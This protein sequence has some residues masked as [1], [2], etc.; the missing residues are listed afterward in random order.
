M[1]RFLFIQE[2]V[3]SDHTIQHRDGTITIDFLESTTG[4]R[5]L[6]ELRKHG[7]TRKDINIGYMYP[8]VPE[9]TQVTNAGKPISYKDVTLT[10]AR[11]YEEQI[12]NQIIEEKPEVVIPNGR[13]GC[14]FLV[15]KVSITATRGIPVEKTVE[16]EDGDSHTF[17]ILPTFSM[18]YVILKP[19][20][21]RHLHVDLEMLSNFKEQGEKA[22]LPS[23]VEY[24]FVDDIEEVKKIFKYIKESK[25]VVAWDLET[26]TLKPEMKGSKA[27]VISVSWEEKTGY[28]I[29]IQHKEFE[30]AEEDLNTLMKLIEDFVKDKEV[31]KV[32]ANIKYDLRFLHSAYGFTEFNNHMDIQIAYWMVISQDRNNLRRLG[33]LAYEFTDMGGYDNDLE[34]WKDN[35]IREYRKEHKKP[36]VNEVDGSNFN[37]EWFPLKMLV[38]YAS[39]DVD[40]TLRIHNVL[41]KKVETNE[42][43][44]KLYTD[45]YPRMS[46][47]IAVTEAN[48]LKLD[49]DYARKIAKEYRKE[50][51]RIV[52]R[53]RELPS[54]QVVESEYKE[55][56]EMGLAEMAKKP[57]DRDKEIAKWRN[58]YKT[59]LKFNPRSG[60]DKGKVLFDVLNI[61]LP[62]ERDY[63]KDKP[64][65][66]KNPKTID[67]L[68][69]EDF[70]TNK[71]VLQEIVSG[72]YGEEASKLASLMLE[73]SSVATL[74]STFADKA[75]SDMA[76]DGAIHGNLNI[77]GTGT[78]RLSSSQPNLQNIPATHNN[79]HK[80]DYHHPIKRMYVSRFDDGVILEADYSAL[81]MRILGLVAGDPEM[82]KTF[83]EDG[84][85]HNN[86]ASII[87]HKAEDEVTY[88]EREASKAISFGIIYGKGIPGLATDLGI[89]PEEAQVV[90][91][92]FMSSKP[93][94]AQY[95]NSVHQ[96]V[97]EHGYVETLQGH[98]R[99]L[100]DIFGNRVAEAGAL[101]QSV[102]T[103]IQGTG[104]YLTNLS[105]VMLHEYIL[106]HNK[107]TKVIATVHDSI[108][109]DIPEDEIEEMTQVIRIIMENLPIDFLNVDL[110]DGIERYPIASD[111][112]IGLNYSDLVEFD[113]DEYRTFN[114]AKG[115]IK[116]HRDIHE[117]VANK[118]SEVITDEQADQLLAHIENN[119]ANYQQ[120]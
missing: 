92:Q 85:I 43:W 12:I 1:S 27:L 97:K 26:N 25:K 52:E 35:Y 89:T 54:V 30:W 14:K 103:I 36:P 3:R 110:G 22:F 31:F 59:K 66:N 73:F 91:D 32:G 29:P 115:Y 64:W 47:A 67:D 109:L 71:E 37:Y 117:I 100:Q 119:K 69:W 95:I 72:G 62:F 120:I 111:V 34:E 42:K 102:N 88:D 81:E 18:E 118:D 56:Y 44:I 104:A 17:W 24:D 107:R 61:K 82:T 94:V 20:V 83:K 74:R 65:L 10:E 23:E 51:A 50:E 87:N 86:T 79:I 38:E 33:N 105:V 21:S 76:D 80:F 68:S 7:I 77:V 106:E 108:A 78:S 98:R 70:S 16:N 55:Y 28:T 90:Y 19:S 93:S 15:D 116:F 101:R 58:K 2:H 41:Y 112:E 11:E 75:E 48:G 5:L 4:K 13:L 39:G 8:R 84:D 114:S 40:A 96:F 60:A 57:A 53:I 46:S 9:V 113:L 99:N 63:I 45:F 6:T 49:L